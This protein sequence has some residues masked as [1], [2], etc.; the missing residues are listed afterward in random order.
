AY[1]LYALSLSKAEASGAAEKFFSPVYSA[2]PANEENAGI[3][4]G[5]LKELFRYTQD[6]K[7]AIEARDIYAN[8]FNQTESYYTGINA[9]S[10]FALTGKSVTAKEIAN[11]ILAKLS[12]DTSD[13]WEI[14]TIAEAKLLLKK[15]QEAVEFYSRGRK[16]AGK[17]WGKI[18]SVYK[19]LWMINH[20]FP[21]PSSVIKAF[22]PPKIGVFVGHMVDREGGNVRFP[23]SIVPQIKQAIDERLKSLDIQIGY[24][25]LACGGD[26]LFA[27]ALT[28]NNGDVNV[29]LPF[30][31]E[32]FLKTSVSFAG[33]EWVDRFEKLEQKWPLHFLTDEQF[34]GNNDL[35]LL[36]GRSL[37][38]FALLRAQMTHSEPYFITVLASS[39][40]QRKEGGTRDLL[41]LWPKEEHHFNIDPGN[42][43]TNE[44]RKSSSTFIEQEQPWR[45]L[46]IGY[47]DFPH[48]ALV[49]AELNK[50][51]DRYRS[52]FED[53]LIFSESKSGKLLIGLNSSYGAL[54]L[55]RKI[56]NDYKIKTGRSDYRSV[57]HA[58]SVQLSN[59]QL[60]GLEVENIIE[61]MKY[62]LPENLMCTSAYATSLILDPGHFK[63]HYAGSI[64]NKL[65]MYS[66][67]VS[68]F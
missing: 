45:V 31:K 3:M 44:I 32:D 18:N 24:C 29:Y 25:S 61:A 17:D 35:F 38:G 67:E 37:I 55:A 53:E 10:M 20:Y 34:H 39:D 36:H 9:A 14:V 2:T 64:R 47:L 1:H 46:Y 48:L 52:E 33:Q 63:F 57:F 5:I 49:D 16:L 13:F 19:Q 68:E 28:E 12:I 30:P 59:N 65:E 60:N 21:V 22:S 50:I 8:N 54:R 56:I 27:E 42:F 6:Q 23:K 66:L 41:K 4:G 40:T 43:A 7:Y 15:S 26:I 11:K 58:A 62:A 51:V